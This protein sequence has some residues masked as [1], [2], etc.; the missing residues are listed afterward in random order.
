MQEMLSYCGLTCQTCPIHLATIES[1][2]EK[3]REMRIDIA[4]Q[5]KERYGQECK[6]EDVNDCDGC[7]TETGRLYFGCKNC[8]IRKCA[9]EKKLENCAYCN[10]YP[11]EELEQ[12]FAIEPV[13]KEQLDRIKSEL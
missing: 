10:D 1:D 3:K 9:G 4:Q 6:P 12:V 8:Q 11:C 13:I 2:D 7:K 5:I